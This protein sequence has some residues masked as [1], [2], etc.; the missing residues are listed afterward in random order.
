MKSRVALTKVLVAILALAAGTVVLVKVLHGGDEKAKSETVV[1]VADRTLTRQD[2]RREAK[3]L[4]RLGFLGEQWPAH[5]VPDPPRYERCAHQLRS[6]GV[7]DGRSEA[8]QDVLTAA[9]A[10][11]DESLQ[12]WAAMTLI[13]KA[14]M[15]LSARQHHTSIEG[16]R[17]LARRKFAPDE[18]EMRAYYQDNRRRFKE[19]VREVRELVIEDYPEAERLANALRGN[20]VTFE[21]LAR[22][23]EASKGYEVVSQH[24]AGYYFSN[25]LTPK[26]R[27]LAVKQMRA[28]AGGWVGPVAVTGGWVIF[29]ARGKPRI[30]MMPYRLA[31]AHIRRGLLQGAI[32]EH[33]MQ[34]RKRWREITWCVK[35]LELSLKRFCGADE[36]GKLSRDIP[37]YYPVVVDPLSAA[38]VGE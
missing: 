36:P 4:V 7:G 5:V 29:Q 10:K 20:S 15:E 21:E 1:Q 8:T 13:Q 23:Y 30:Q 16:L 3:E 6:A 17:A 33:N 25:R 9:C 28:R 24:G 19:R 38:D 31:K 12:V 37:P 35:E 27:P 26:P 2:F 14:W 18:A 34:A 32:S 11:A 22:E